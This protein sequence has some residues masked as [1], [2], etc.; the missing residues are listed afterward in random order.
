MHLVHAFTRKGFESLRAVASL[1]NRL[2]RSLH[3][4]SNAL[5]NWLVW[6]AI[7]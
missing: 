7:H 6:K 5:H 4:Q 2:S 1:I 3:Y